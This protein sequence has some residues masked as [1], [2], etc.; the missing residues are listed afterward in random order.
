MTA[1]RSGLV[2][3]LALAAQGCTAGAVW[4]RRHTLA[5]PA[6]ENRAGA[7]TRS[8][9]P[10]SDSPGGGGTSPAL[11]NTAKPDPTLELDGPP[12]CPLTPTL[13]PAGGEGDCVDLDRHPDLDLDRN[14]DQRGRRGCARRG[15][16]ARRPAI[17]GA[18]WR[19]LWV[20]RARRSSGRRLPGRDARC[21]PTARDAQALHAL[22]SARGAL[23]SSRTPAAGD[24][25]FLADRPGGA[26]A[27]VGIVTRSEADGTAMVLHRTRFGV[28]RLRVNLAYPSRP[29]DPA[30][31]K[32]IN[33]TLL[34]GGRSEP[35]GKLVVGV[36]DLLRRGASPL[37]ATA[38]QPSSEVPPYERPSA[39]LPAT[40]VPAIGI[41]ESRASSTDMRSSPKR[42]RSASAPSRKMPAPVLRE[43]SVRRAPGEGAQRLG[44]GEPLP[45]QPRL[46]GAGGRRPSAAAR[47]RRGSG[48]STG[49]SDPNA[50]GIPAAATCRQA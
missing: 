22:A 27:H 43:G 5:P 48:L 32:H 23:T 15:V 16:I 17:G 25:V 33:D 11:R 2:V 10:G 38:R 31:G 21:L 29:T 19:R 40:T 4:N 45:R 13:F 30:T 36:S 20:R 14:L 26:P 41:S 44:A 47:P 6:T 8:T 12:H 37:P 7:P 24:L 1:L 34:V 35:A 3:A 49:K 39:T 46:R 18:G 42:V 50:S 28:L 9:G